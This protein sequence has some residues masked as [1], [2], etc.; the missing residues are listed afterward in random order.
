MLNS[1]QN[2]NCSEYFQICPNNNCTEMLTDMVI[3]K[4]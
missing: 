1:Y 4:G 2:G 3:K